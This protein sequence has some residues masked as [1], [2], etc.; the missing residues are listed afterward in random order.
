[1]SGRLRVAFDVTPTIGRVTGV[2]GFTLHLRD[3]LLHRSDVELVPY[4]VTWRGRRGAGAQRVAMPARAM[5]RAWLRSDH[6]VIERFTGRVDVVHGTNFVVPPT[7]RAGAIVSV[8]DLTVV[9]FP[10]LCT[11]DTLQ[12]PALVRRAMQRGAHVHTDSA[13]VAGEVAAWLGLG[14]E[15]I[16]V[17]APGVALLPPAYGPAAFG[18]R[19]FV[20]ALGTVE[21]RKDLPSLI[22]AF[23]ALASGHPDPLLVIAGPDGWGS[24]ALARAIANLPS[25]IRTR[26]IRRGWVDDQTR[27]A[28]L[29]DAS[30]FAYPSLYEGFGFPPL[31]AMQAGVPVVATSTGSLPEVL[32]DAAILVDPGDVAALAEAIERL[33]CDAAAAAAMVQR[34]RDHVVGMTWDASAAAMLDAYRSIGVV[35]AYA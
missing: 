30:V 8:H 14:A 33:L 9:R 15:R 12:Y 24:D 19:P 6:P 35:G 32:G 22:G 21:P 1:M 2:G 31:E 13:F 27:A 16:H 3:A 23:A 10:E 25:I 18:G 11:A 4:A 20:L 7:R 28:L 26:I 29:R 34:G 17:V 5:R